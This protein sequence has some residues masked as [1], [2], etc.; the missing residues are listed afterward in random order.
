MAYLVSENRIFL[1]ASMLQA[2]P[3]NYS[4]FAYIPLMTLRDSTLFEKFCFN[5]T[6][7]KASTS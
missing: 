2:P 3:V 6:I 1:V 7:K 4:L 5:H